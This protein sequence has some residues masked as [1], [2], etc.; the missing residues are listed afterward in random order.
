MS[1]FVGA[2][3]GC[4]VEITGFF[5]GEEDGGFFGRFWALSISGEGRKVGDG[6]GRWVDGGA[7]EGVVDGGAL[8]FLIILYRLSYCFPNKLKYNNTKYGQIVI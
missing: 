3:S 1:L 8:T 6:V 4:G 5:I 2:F 7:V